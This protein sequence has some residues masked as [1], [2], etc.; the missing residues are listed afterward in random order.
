VWSEVAGGQ[1][2]WLRIAGWLG[3]SCQHHTP[4]AVSHKVPPPSLPAACRLL[5]DPCTWLRQLPSSLR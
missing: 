4:C 3:S 1:V 2:S 5:G